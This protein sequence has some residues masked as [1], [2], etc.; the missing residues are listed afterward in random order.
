V[1]GAWHYAEHG[2]VSKPGDFVYEVANSRHTFIADE[3]DE[4]ILFVSMQGP[5]AFLGENDEI[6]GIETAH[7]FAARYEAFCI[8]QGLEPIDLTEFARS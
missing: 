5:I 8:E 1:Q 3:G 2:W 6:V 4:V 7:T